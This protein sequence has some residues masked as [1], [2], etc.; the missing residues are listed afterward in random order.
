MF[1]ARGIVEG[2]SRGLGNN[3][4]MSARVTWILDLHDEF[5]SSGQLVELLGDA[6][7]VV[8]R[9]DALLGRWPEVEG[10]V[11]GYGTML[12]MSRLAAHPELGHAVF[13]DYPR[14]K[15]SSYYRWVY[16]LLGRKAVIVPFAALSHLR[17]EELFGPRVFIRSD[18]NYKLFSAGVHD[19]TEVPEWVDLYKAHHDELVVLSEP[20]RIDQEYRCFF[21]EGRFVCGSSHP[22]PPFGEVPDEVITFAGIAAARLHDKG[23][24]MCTVDVAIGDKLRLVEA[25]GVNSWGL[26]G[27]STE[28]FI[29][30]LEDE[31]L[32][33][34]EDL[35]S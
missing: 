6:A 18:S 31:A 25:G 13:D 4:A 26:Y 9:Q 7:R 32:R 29:A 10:P 8:T 23:L 27:S 5:P 30:A 14:L 12:T 24:A 3:D 11:V 15:C 22:D 34:H 1:A 20:V 21:R 16:D 35:F 28:A 33:V 2:T 17:L 19:I